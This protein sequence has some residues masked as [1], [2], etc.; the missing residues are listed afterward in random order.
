MWTQLAKGFLKRPSIGEGG[1]TMELLNLST[2]QL[3]IMTDSLI[4][5]YHL[6]GH[7]LNWGWY[8][9]PTVIAASMHLKQP[10]IF[11]VTVGLRPH[12]NSGTWVVIFRNQ[13]RLRTSLGARYCTSFKVQGS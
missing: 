1:G 4:G 9:V 11:F 10:H 3:V 6:K 8:T 7:L 13:V 12:Y 5:H 2:N